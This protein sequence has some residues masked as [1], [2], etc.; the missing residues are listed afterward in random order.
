MLG[1]EV[2]PIAEGLVLAPASASV[3][4][5]G[6]PDSMA[7]AFLPESVHLGGG[8]M[9]LSLH[10]LAWL[11]QGLTLNA[12]IVYSKSSEAERVK[13]RELSR[14]SFLQLARLHGNWI[15]N[16]PFGLGYHLL[17]TLDLIEGLEQ[18]TG[19]S[20][21]FESAVAYYRLASGQF[22]RREDPELFAVIFNNA[23]VAMIAKATTLEE[24]YQGSTWLRMAFDTAN[25][26][27][28]VPLG[29]KLALYNLQI[30][31]QASSTNSGDFNPG[32]PE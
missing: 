2:S 21:F 29:S 9:E 18:D 8:P 22:Q 24:F 10:A 20:A 4:V 30:I 28:K 1:R 27:K 25:G 15:S 17:G 3:R 26:M 19:V 6:L 14:D 7:L 32:L 12:K 5:P 31:D 13:A 11:G 16:G 23:G